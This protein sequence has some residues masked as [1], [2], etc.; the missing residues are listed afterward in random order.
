[1]NPADGR[2]VLGFENTL[3]AHATKDGLSSDRLPDRKEKSIL[4]NLPSLLEAN[5]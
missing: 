5:R 1:M 4:G 2:E 3:L